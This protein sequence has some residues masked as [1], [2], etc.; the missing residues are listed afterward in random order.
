MKNY[1]LILFS[2]LLIQVHAQDG[3]RIEQAKIGYITN[4]LN[5][6]STEAEKFW[7]LYNEYKSKIKTIRKEM[8]MDM[9]EIQNLDAIS[10]KEAETTLNDIISSEQRTLI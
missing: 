7:P 1:I 3:S 10:D 4:K 5:L 8:R 6:S 9:K 2:L